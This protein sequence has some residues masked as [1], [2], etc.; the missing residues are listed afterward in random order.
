[1][2]DAGPDGSPASTADGGSSGTDGGSADGGSS[3]GGS[4]D[5]GSNDG[6]VTDGG[7]K[8]GGSADAGTVTY[9]D[10]SELPQG[11]AIAA[12]SL[13]TFADGGYS[14]FGDMTT[15]F[16]GGVRIVQV[17]S[18]SSNTVTVIYVDAQHVVATGHLLGGPNVD[19][20]YQGTMSGGVLD[21]IEDYD[22]DGDGVMDVEH[23]AHY[24]G[25]PL[26][27][28]YSGYDLHPDGG[29]GDGGIALLWTYS[30]PAQQDSG[31]RKADCDP[32]TPFPSTDG[33][34]WSPWPN[35]RISIPVNGSPGSCDENQ[36][37]AITTALNAALSDARLC[38]VGSN[39]E[40]GAKLATV[41]GEAAA[42][43]RA[44]VIG[45]GNHCTNA[46]TT[47]GGSFRSWFENLGS[48]QHMNLNPALIDG[49][50]QNLESR[51][52]H[53]M[54]H[55]G[56]SL[57]EGGEDGN[58]GTD[59]IYTCARYCTGCNDGGSNGAGS[60]A[61]DCAT[62]RVGGK[63]DCG[64]TVTFQAVDCETASSVGGCTGGCHS[65]NG[66]SGAA[67][68]QWMGWRETA[69]DG[70]FLDYCCGEPFAFCCAMCPADHPYASTEACPASSPT[71]STCDQRP[72][73]CNSSSC[74]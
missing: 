17:N 38:L 45:C 8:D 55:W 15:S 39:P 44:L 11:W 32:N 64:T 50:C 35:S 19:Y 33:N 61:R 60:P 10:P 6:G 56:G 37:K 28:T 40:L 54:L 20:T 1:V 70:T 58:G 27:L 26:Q 73:F 34:W 65:A 3:D 63:R 5:G 69:C 16:D 29:T 30:G 13:S 9:P 24:E 71:T 31:R 47:N 22:L 18:Q 42:G 43:E 41:L 12:A 4:T 36:A 72:L 51:M 74:P 66:G 59:P 7:S 46:N 57:H 49:G 62:C 67:C 2:T 68:E 14:Y 25:S 48:G 21:E 52:L 23:R 53:E